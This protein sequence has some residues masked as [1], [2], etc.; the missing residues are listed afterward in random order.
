MVGK[1]KFQEAPDPVDLA[2]PRRFG[3]PFHKIREPK[4]ICRFDA[5]W[6]LQER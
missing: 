4:E 6:I 1:L 5:D 3:W 2:F